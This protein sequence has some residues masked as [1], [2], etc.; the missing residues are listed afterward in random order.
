M[1]EPIANDTKV[2][3][4]RLPVETVKK[5][6]DRAKTGESNSKLLRRIIDSFLKTKLKSKR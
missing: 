6:Y 4:F 5:L 2:L 3:A 1:N